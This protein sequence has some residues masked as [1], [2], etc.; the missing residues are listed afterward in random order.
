MPAIADVIVMLET[1]NR[2]VLEDLVNQH[3]P[4]YEIVQLDTSDKPTSRES[5]WPVDKITARQS[6]NGSPCAF[7]R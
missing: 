1:E 3:L 6:T 2:R 5:C 4:G 7:R